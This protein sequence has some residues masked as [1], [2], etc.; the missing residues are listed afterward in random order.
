[1]W[2][3]TRKD[4]KA[5]V[6]WGMEMGG[7]ERAG[8]RNEKKKKKESV[9][10]KEAKALRDQRDLLL[11]NIIKEGNGSCHV[12]TLAASNKLFLSGFV[13]SASTMETLLLIN[14]GEGFSILWNL[15]NAE[16]PTQIPQLPKIIDCC[17]LM[18]KMKNLGRRE[19]SV[20]TQLMQHASKNKHD[21]P[22]IKPKTRR[23]EYLR[24]LKNQM[25]CNE[26]CIGHCLFN[27]NKKPITFLSKSRMY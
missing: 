3:F 14:L 4:A 19:V 2:L 16:L 21:G 20:Y 7:C 22:R 23:S 6:A 26:L 17:S 13:T 12:D 11:C 27:Q 18:L 8:P 15:E 24:R 25:A 10:L 1:D 9:R 5:D